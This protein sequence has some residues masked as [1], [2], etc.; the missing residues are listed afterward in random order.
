M[1]SRICGREWAHESSAPKLAAAESKRRSQN[2]PLGANRDHLRRPVR[3]GR[4]RAAK[5]TAARRPSSKCWAGF[6]RRRKRPPRWAA[7]STT[8]TCSSGKRWPGCWRLV[9]RSPKGPA[10]R[11]PR[12]SLLPS[13]GNSKRAAASACAKRHWSARRS[14]P[15]VSLPCRLLRRRAAKPRRGGRQEKEWQSGRRPTVRA[16]RAAETVRRNSSGENFAGKLENRP[17]GATEETSRTTK[18]EQN[19]DAQG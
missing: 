9:S 1:H 6:A 18:K 19:G 14:G 4:R 13:S 3:W 15:S 8:T 17:E 12:R 2:G 5:R 7:R 11:A 16:L 10:N